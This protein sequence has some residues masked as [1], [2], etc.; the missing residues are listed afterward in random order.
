MGSAWNARWRAFSTTV[1]QILCLL[2]KMVWAGE[3][4]DQGELETQEIS[5]SVEFEDVAVLAIQTDICHLVLLT[6]KLQAWK[7]HARAI[8]SQ[9]HGVTLVCRQGYL[10]RQQVAEKPIYG[11]R[12]QR[13]L[14]SG[15]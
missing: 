2:E 6:K 1:C 15:D 8:P 7:V 4:Q 12:Y 14:A 3:E 11:L 5:L 9:R 13:L 10:V